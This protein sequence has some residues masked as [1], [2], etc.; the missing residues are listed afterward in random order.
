MKKIKSNISPF[1][2]IFFGCNRFIL[3]GNTFYLIDTFSLKRSIILKQRRNVENKIDVSLI[4]GWVF[5]YLIILTIYPHRIPTWG[6]SD[7]V[8][9]NLNRYN[10][11]TSTHTHT[12]THIHISAYTCKHIYAHAQKKKYTHIVLILCLIVYIEKLYNTAI[13]TLYT[14]YI[15]FGHLINKVSKIKLIYRKTLYNRNNIVI[16]DTI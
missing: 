8:E 5:L 16:E 13:Y 14:Y 6:V 11:L 10:K 12:Q 9:H 7:W 15:H 3:S 4:K 1:L 2:P